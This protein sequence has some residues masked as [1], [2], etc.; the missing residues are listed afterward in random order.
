MIASA[1]RGDDMLITVDDFN[2]ADELL[3]VTEMKMPQTFGGMG[4]DKLA[5]VT[6]RVMER[7]GIDKIVYFDELVGAFWRDANKWDLER[8]L[9]TLTAMKFCTRGVEGGRLYF[10]YK[11]EEETKDGK[12]Y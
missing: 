8:I 12:L 2:R 4:R 5:E 7:I 3:K 9:S 10:K 11:E 1:S 6:E